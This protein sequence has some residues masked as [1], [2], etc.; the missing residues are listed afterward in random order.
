MN[1]LLRVFALPNEIVWIKETTLNI[2]QML[3]KCDVSVIV[4]ENNVIL[5]D[6]EIIKL[7]AKTT[8]LR[9]GNINLAQYLIARIVI[10]TA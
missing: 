6:L 5:H 9:N 2:D 10:A 1:Y 7:I 3:Y 4:E 8:K